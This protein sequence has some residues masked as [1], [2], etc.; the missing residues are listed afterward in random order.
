MFTGRSHYGSIVTS[1]QAQRLAIGLRALFVDLSQGALLGLAHGADEQYFA[2][3]ARASASDVTLVDHDADASE[4]DSCGI[5]GEVP[6]RGERRAVLRGDA[7]GEQNDDVA[8][9]VR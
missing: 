8:E 1:H 5:T 6:I 7:V 3:A 2:D 4:P 9:G